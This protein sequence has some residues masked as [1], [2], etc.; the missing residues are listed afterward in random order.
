L[1]SF[2]EKRKTEERGEKKSQVKNQKMK[3]LVQH[4][5]RKSSLLLSAVAF[6]FFFWVNSL[7][8]SDKIKQDKVSRTIFGDSLISTNLNELMQP[9]LVRSVDE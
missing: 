4:D 8:V 5:A 7:V 6:S 2:F 3:E 9:S 1:F